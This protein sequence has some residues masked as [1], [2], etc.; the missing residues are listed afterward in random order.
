MYHATNNP[1]LVAQNAAWR[2]DET[3]IFYY[4]GQVD[5]AIPAWDVAANFELAD[6]ST[7]VLKAFHWSPTGG[8]GGPEFWNRAQAWIAGHHPSATGSAPV[9]ALAVTSINGASVSLSAAGSQAWEYDWSYTGGAMTAD[10]YNIVSWDYDFGDG[11]RTN[12][13]PS[14]S[15]TYAQAG[16]YLVT[17]T[18]TDGAG[19]R[20]EASVPVTVNQGSGANPQLQVVADIP[21]I[22]PEEQQNSFLVRL[23]EPP[24]GNIPVSV[25]RTGGD[26]DLSVGSGASLIFT[27]ANWSVFQVVTLAAAS[28]ADRMSSTA[29]FGV[30][31]AG[32]TTVDVSAMERDDDAQFLVVVGS[33]SVLPGETVSVP[34]A[35]AN[36]DG[37][38]VASFSIT[39]GFDGTALTSPFAIRGADLPGP[40]WWE[41][42]ATAPSAGTQV[43]E[44]NEF[45][46]PANPIISGVVAEASFTVPEGTSPGLYSVAVVATTIN[47]TLQATGES[48]FVTVSAGGEI[49]AIHKWGAAALV[50]LLISSGAVILGRA[51][52]AVPASF[53]ERSTNVETD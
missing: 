43:L 24:E 42:S 27:P 30:A 9:A 34:I 49:P 20:D 25:D 29:T 1:F 41:F 6:P 23:T 46:Q 45:V 17:L 16:N 4:G 37:A 14:V 18:I 51:T 52:R 7:P 40:A 33:A 22:V 26:V 35:L 12:W 50:L 36:N 11:T 15:H 21:E 3:A 28:D 39:L 38:S 13:G 8:H 31:A 10:N 53:Q 19:L 44:G 2:L 5:T 48:G 32:L 47:G